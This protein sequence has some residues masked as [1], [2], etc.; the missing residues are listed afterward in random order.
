MGGLLPTGDSPPLLYTG[1]TDPPPPLL[2]LPC[3]IF[4]IADT[5]ST[6][7]CMAHMLLAFRLPSLAPWPCRIEL[8]EDVRDEGFRL[9][10]V[11]G[12]ALRRL[13]L[14]LLLWCVRRDPLPV[15]P[16]LCLEDLWRELLRLLL[17]W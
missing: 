6:A 2:P 7:A 17:P 8:D 12:G 5:A 11:P 14:L 1:L 13:W 4:L 16:R 10:T 9:F 3:R 15:L